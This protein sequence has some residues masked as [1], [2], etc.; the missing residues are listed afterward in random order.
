VLPPSSEQNVNLSLVHTKTWTT[1][2]LEKLRVAQIAKNVHG[3][4]YPDANKPSPQLI[5]R[6]FKVSVNRNGSPFGLSN[7]CSF[8]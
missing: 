7:K 4:S 8:R 1:N 6:L 2:L 5:S 3:L